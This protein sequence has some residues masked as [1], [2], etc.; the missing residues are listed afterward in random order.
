MT[1]TTLFLASFALIAA[2]LQAV[3][4]DGQSLTV[5]IYN[6]A[7]VDAAL[8][9]EAA[10]TA[11][12]IYRRSEVETRWVLCELPGVESDLDQPCP[13]AQSPDTI[14]MRIAP[15][16]PKSQEGVHETVFGFALPSKGGFGTIASAFWDR[17][18]TTA[19]K[20]GM[21]PVHLLAFVMAHEAGH[22]LLGRNSHSQEGIMGAEWDEEGVVKIAQGGVSFIGSQKKRLR[23]G[24]EAR[25]LAAAN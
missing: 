20:S 8:V 12:A 21:G 22:L 15:T 13:G 18:S 17:I 24:A 6:Y 4:P 23:K 19:G 16:A 1:K 5:R 2:P 9:L 7:G 3:A 11:E 10:E 25:L 14:L